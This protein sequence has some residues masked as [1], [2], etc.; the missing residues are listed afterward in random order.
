MDKD[1]RANGKNLVS[2]QEGGLLEQA[3]D[4]TYNNNEPFS[5]RLGTLP[6]EPDYM[7]EGWAVDHRVDEIFPNPYPGPIAFRS[8]MRRIF[9]P[10]RKNEMNVRFLPK[11]VVLNDIEPE[12]NIGFA[13]DIMPLFKYDLSFDP[14]VK[15]FFSD[16]ELI[17]ANFE[18]I[19]S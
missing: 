5:L 13:G 15:E 6:E 19:I 9:G 14:S 4:A 3:N 16:V 12:F 17:V 11:K 2:K 7:K 8:I 10:R 18:G 1:K